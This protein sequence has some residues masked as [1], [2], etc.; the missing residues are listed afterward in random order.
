MTGIEEALFKTLE[1]QGNRGLKRYSQWVW[2]KIMG[3]F[4]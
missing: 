4:K 3:A 2:E 1:K